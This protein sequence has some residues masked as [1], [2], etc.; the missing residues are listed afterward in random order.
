MIMFLKVNPMKAVGSENQ[1]SLNKSHRLLVQLNN[2]TVYILVTWQVK[3]TGR[4]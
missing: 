3:S 2:D 4:F 1:T